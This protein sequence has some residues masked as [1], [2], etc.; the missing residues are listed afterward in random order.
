MPPIIKMP[1]PQY[2]SSPGRTA[3]GNSDGGTR[4]AFFPFV[5]CPKFGR[6]MSLGHKNIKGARPLEDG[7]V[8]NVMALAKQLASVDPQQ[9]SP[10]EESWRLN[11]QDSKGDRYD[12]VRTGP[13]MSPKRK[14]S[15]ELI[16]GYLILLAL[17]IVVFSVWIRTNTGEIVGPSE[18]AAGLRKSEDTIAVPQS[19]NTSDSAPTA[20]ESLRFAEFGCASA[21]CT[22]RCNTNERIANAFA[23]SPGATFV[24]QDDRTVSVRPPLL[25]SN[26]I[27]LVCVPQ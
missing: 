8:A 22:V 23:L 20:R 15:W 17:A 7:S 24:Y 12:P 9:A 6:I 25:P 21:V 13:V 16:I 11:H 27:V 5:L 4:Q 3:A 19:A 14:R 18:P 26:K 2:R 10:V 1:R